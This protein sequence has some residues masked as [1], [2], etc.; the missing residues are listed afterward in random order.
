MHDR[1]KVRRNDLLSY[2][3]NLQ[4]LSDGDLSDDS[5]LEAVDLMKPLRTPCG[6]RKLISKWSQYQ[7]RA[8]KLTDIESIKHATLC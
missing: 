8:G 4:D 6:K 2:E 7:K 3:K 5:R 1:L